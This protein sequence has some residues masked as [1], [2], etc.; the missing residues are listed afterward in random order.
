MIFISSIAGHVAFPNSAAYCASKGAV[1]LL[2]KA[3]ATEFSPRIRVNVIAPGN[4][5]T[6]MNA[7]L[8]AQPGYEDAAAELTP[9]GRHGDPEEI[10]AAVL[11]VASDAAS[12]VHGASFLVDGGWTAR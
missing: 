10:A 6:P 5:R 1:E 3:L 11:F 9:A 4:I 12:F 7:A 2:A 8:R